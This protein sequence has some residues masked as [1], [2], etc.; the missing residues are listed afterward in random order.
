MRVALYIAQGQSKGGFAECIHPVEDSIDAELFYD[1]GA[2]F[3]DH[4]CRMNPVATVGLG[5]DPE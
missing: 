2:F 4:A 5:F 3:V 1:N